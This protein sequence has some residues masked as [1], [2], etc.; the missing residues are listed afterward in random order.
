MKISTTFW[1][2][3]KILTHTPTEIRRQRLFAKIMIALEKAAKFEQ[4]CL[5]TYFF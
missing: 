2:Q 1:V 5:E 4:R 3:G